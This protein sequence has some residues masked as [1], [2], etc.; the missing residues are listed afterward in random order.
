MSS[1]LTSKQ[2]R[3]SAFENRA[4]NQNPGYYP[5]DN[6]SFIDKSIDDSLKRGYTEK[7]VANSNI[8]DRSLQAGQQKG[9]RQFLSE[10]ELFHRAGMGEDQAPTNA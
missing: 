8:Q 6:R 10:E 7:N 5:V 4:D 3:E 2:N 9:S 1:N